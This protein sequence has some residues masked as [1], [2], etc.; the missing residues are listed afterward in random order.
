VDPSQHRRWRQKS[1]AEIEAVSRVA[2]C[3]FDLERRDVLTDAQIV[4]LAQAIDA[5]ELGAFEA[6]PPLTDQARAAEAA[7]GAV[8]GPRDRA[9]ALVQGLALKH[10][11]GKFLRLA[12]AT[13]PAWRWR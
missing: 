10:L 9:R 11:R 13:D 4:L 7:P 12:G 6:A 1:A 3:L 2:D 8:A 5:L